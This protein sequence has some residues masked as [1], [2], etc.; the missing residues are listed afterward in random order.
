[1]LVS[2]KYNKDKYRELLEKDKLDD[3]QIK[4]EVVPSILDD[5][6]ATTATTTNSTTTIT[7][8]KFVTL[9]Y[10]SQ[11]YMSSP[12]KSQRRRSQNRTPTPP[13]VTPNTTTFPYQKSSSVINSSPVKMISQESSTREAI[14]SP[15]ISAKP[16]SYQDIIEN[17]GNYNLQYIL[18][19]GN[20]EESSSIIGHNQE[21]E[22]DWFNDV[23]SIA[24]RLHLLRE[25]YRTV[26]ILKKTR[27]LGNKRQ[28]MSEFSKSVTPSVS[29]DNVNNNAAILRSASHNRNSTD[30]GISG[31][32]E[33]EFEELDGF[34]EDEDSSNTDT[35]AKSETFV[36]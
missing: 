10:N 22:S 21:V 25:T 7:P 6:S 3:V 24:D 2:F 23:R 5:S 1:M 32:D 13:S 20:N 4:Q 33:D 14:S 16:R 12:S 19:S 17:M 8:T 35:L 36:T 11:A 15:P 31:M 34:E 28:D 30:A 18:N 27:V 26:Q 9:Y 29:G